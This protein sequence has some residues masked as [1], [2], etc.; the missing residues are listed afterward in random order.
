MIAR[1]E[2]GVA[3]ISNEIELCTLD[4]TAPV[5]LA[6]LD[7]VIEATDEVNQ[8]DVIEVMASMAPDAGELNS[9]VGHVLRQVSRIAENNGGSIY[10]GSALLR[11]TEG[12]QPKPYVT[13]TVEQDVG[14]LF[15]DIASIQPVIGVRDEVFGLKLYDVYRQAAPVI[16]ALFA[17][18]PFDEK[19]GRLVNTGKHSHR[20]REYQRMTAKLPDGMTSAPRFTSLKESEEHRKAVAEELRDSLLAG[21]LNPNITELDVIRKNGTSYRQLIEAAELADHQIYNPIRIRESHANE[22]T[23]FTLE[24]RFCDLPISLARIQALNLIVVG[25]A[26]R[27]ELR[28]GFT[29]L[30]GAVANLGLQKKDIRPAIRMASEKGLDARIGQERNLETVSQRLIKLAMEG[31]KHRGIATETLE[32]ELMT[33]LREGNDAQRILSHVM[34]EQKRSGREYT[35]RELEEFLSRTLVQSLAM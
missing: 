30:N 3:R 9:S 13:T 23:V 8:R 22:E 25:L 34:T 10:A 5:L 21:K 20:A 1:I 4:I 7:G 18:S 26:Y 15:M 16:T 28:D 19:D 6:L 31:L 29:V 27:A 2:D 33:I 14:E 32:R 12:L 24:L 11:S 35:P 17:S